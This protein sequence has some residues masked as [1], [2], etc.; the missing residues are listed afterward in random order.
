MT[1]WDLSRMR[2]SHSVRYSST[3]ARV[4]TEGVL[5][6]I[7]AGLVDPQDGS[8]RPLST[9]GAKSQPVAELTISSFPTRQSGKSGRASAIVWATKIQNFARTH[10]GTARAIE[11]LALGWH[12][13]Q[14]TADQARLPCP[15]VRKLRLPL[16][17]VE[18]DSSVGYTVRKSC[19]KVG[20]RADDVRLCT[21]SALR[22]KRSRGKRP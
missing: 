10:I 18:D 8:A 5:C 11:F 21:G 2:A 7:L 22:A 14:R 19:T 15:R 16:H 4:W 17:L 1:G 6:L 20:M 12:R 9:R 3:T 13:A